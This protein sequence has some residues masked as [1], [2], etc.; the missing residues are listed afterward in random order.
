MRKKYQP[1]RVK[2]TKDI[3]LDNKFGLTTDNKPFVLFDSKDQDRIIGFCSPV[4]LKILKKTKQI[5]I[6]GTFKS[7]PKIFYQTYGLHSLLFGQMFPSVYVLL[8]QK[9]ERIYKKML[10]LLKDACL[11]HGTIL[12]LEKLVTD[13]ELASINAFIFIFKISKRLAVNTIL[14]KQSDD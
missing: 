9:T 1:K 5:H 3:V 10:S 4:N 12:S 11:E 2:C 13:F 6:D 8:G 7:T 14:R